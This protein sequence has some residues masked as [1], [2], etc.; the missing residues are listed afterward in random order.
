MYEIEAI[1]L[2]NSSSKKFSG[3]NKIATLKACSKFFLTAVS[4]SSDDDNISTG[5]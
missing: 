5:L 3:N 2:Y 4:T 1:I